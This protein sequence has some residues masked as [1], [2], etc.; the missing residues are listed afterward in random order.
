[1]DKNNNSPE[2]VISVLLQQPDSARGIEDV[3]SGLDSAGLLHTIFALSPDDQRALLR[4]LPP[5]KAAA[6]VEELPDAHVADLI[7]EMPAEDTA[8][9]VENL[10]SDH[11]VDVLKELDAEDADAIIN[12]LDEA[13]ATEIRNLLTYAPDLAGGLMM[14]E[15]ASYPM[16]KTVREVVEDLTGEDRDYSL[17][18]VHYIYVVVRHHT[19]KG[20]IRIR[21][22]VFADPDVNIGSL[23]IPALTVSPDTPLEELEVF[24]DAHDIAAVPVVNSRQ[25]LLGI[26]RRRAVLEALTE[27]SEADSLKAAGIIG[28]DELR[29]MPALVRSRRRLAWLSINIGLNVIAASVIAAYEDTLTAVIALA[30]FLPIVSDMSGCSGNQAVAVSMR[31]LTLGAA[32]PRDVFRVLRKEAVTGVMNGLALGTILGLAAWA[33]KG[34]PILGLVVGAA[35]AINT[36]IAVSIGGTVPLILKRLRFDPAVASGPLLTTVTD[37]CGFFLLLSL[38]SLVLPALVS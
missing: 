27:K 37:M 10:A 18:T 21:D 30:V 26:V 9:I 29:S 7:E 24:F 34:N 3:L 4:V 23:A 8:A 22:L 14:T 11:R 25:A 28:G 19:L 6:L 2:D 12:E 13:D 15:F 33:W 32:V 38:A 1:M 17:L 5:P 16:G 36:V 35:L 20:V 31:E